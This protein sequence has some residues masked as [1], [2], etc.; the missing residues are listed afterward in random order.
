MDVSTDRLDHLIDVRIPLESLACRRAI[1]QGSNGRRQVA[2]LDAAVAELE[3]M[4]QRE[5][6]YGFASADT[7][8]H[9]TLCG[10]ARN[11]VLQMLWESIARQLTVIFGLSTIGKPMATIVEE[12]RR[13]TAVFAAGDPDAMDRELQEHIREQAHDVDYD[14]VIRQRRAA[15]LAG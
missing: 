9:R 13:L 5:D 1:E 12:H 15:R 11:P 8:F 6:V 10:F 4:Q 2:D 3:L 7:A 14:E